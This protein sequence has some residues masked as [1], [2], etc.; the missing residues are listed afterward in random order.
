MDGVLEEEVVAGLTF[1]VGAD[2]PISK[3]VSLAFEVAGHWAD[4]D[5]AQIFATALGG[6]TVRF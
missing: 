1:G 6:L 5:D 4:F 2:F 3:K